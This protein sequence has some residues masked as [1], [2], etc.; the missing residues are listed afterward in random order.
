MVKTILV[1]DPD[2]SH[3]L[4]IKRALNQ[5]GRYDAQA[6]SRGNPA[7]SIL[8]KKVHDVV[9]ID[10][11]LAYDDPADLMK[12][13]Q[14]TQPDARVAVSSRYPEDET[15]ANELGAYRFIPKPYG[16]RELIDH[17]EAIAGQSRPL[18]PTQAEPPIRMEDAAAEA[19][20]N[21]LLDAT[22]RNPNTMINEPPPDDDDST[23]S[24]VINAALDP[25]VSQRIQATLDPDPLPEDPSQVV[26]AHPLSNP[27]PDIE[28]AERPSPAR[29]VLDETGGTDSLD[30]LLEEIRNF[31]NGGIEKPSMLFEPTP[32]TLQDIIARTAP[33][34]MLESLRP[35]ILHLP[36]EEDTRYAAIPPPPTLPELP[37]E[38]LAV[39]IEDELRA[40]SLDEITQQ[41]TAVE[42]DDIEESLQKEAEARRISTHVLAHYT[43]QIT[44]FALESAAWGALIMQDGARMT[45]SGDLEGEVW[46]QIAGLVYDHWQTAGEARTHVLYR[47]LDVGE[48]LLYSIRTVDDLTLTVVFSAETPLKV[49]RRQAA[50]L[51]A[52]L[53]EVPEMD[54]EA[55][56]DTQ[57]IT[58][59]PVPPPDDIVPVPPA[60]EP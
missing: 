36:S 19:W 55:L 48:V 44:Q 41:L 14:A 32:Q 57:A 21:P 27:A 3:A 29:M 28:E 1:I 43:L 9:I 51:T 24:E 50:R 53:R 11:H 54:D 16:A 35:P 7:L 12:A 2:L 10:L 37:P 31:A 38:A 46:D 40:A 47:R 25:D 17:I 58:R 59:Q 45:Q 52:S 26:A 8:H 49:I 20:I 4:N 33:P 39:P 30:T 6:V 15:R 18:Q 42:L 23:I 34:S 60:P 56:L 5:T 13:I 22:R